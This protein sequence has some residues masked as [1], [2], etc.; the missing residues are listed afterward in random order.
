MKK[1]IAL[2]TL[3]AWASVSRA[4]PPLATGDVPTATAG[5][6]EIYEGQQYQKNADNSL[7][8]ATSTEFAFG[9]NDRLEANFELP[10]LSESTTQGWG[11]TTIGS[12]YMFVTEN[13]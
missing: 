4:G 9:I 3:A 8:R 5:I 11:D 2:L 10:Y 12:K 1:S 6:L 7:E 13:S